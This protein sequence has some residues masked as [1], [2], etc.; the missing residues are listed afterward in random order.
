MKAEARCGIQGAQT[1]QG[2]VGTF[3][4]RKLKDATSTKSTHWENIA[5]SCNICMLRTYTEFL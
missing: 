3:P 1:I 4:C 2:K 5:Y